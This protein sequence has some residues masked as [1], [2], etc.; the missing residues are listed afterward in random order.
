MAHSSI[1][2]LAR[3]VLFMLFFVV[4][5]HWAACLFIYLGKWQLANAAAGWV[6]AQ[7]GLFPWLVGTCLRFV[8][9]TRLYTSALYWTLTT[10]FTVGFGDIVPTSNI[11]RCYAITLQLVGGILQGIVFGNIGV[12][13]Y[14]FDHTNNKLRTALSD[15]AALQRCHHLPDALAKRMRSC[16]RYTWRQTQGLNTPYLLSDLGGA[17]KGDV[18]DAQKHAAAFSNSATFSDLPAGFVRALIG[19]L[20]MQAFLPDALIADAGE[21]GSELFFI[22]EGTVRVSEPA[23]DASGEEESPPSFDDSGPVLLKPGDMFGEAETILCEKRSFTYKAEGFVTCFAL[24]R[25]DLDIVLAN[26][27][28][29]VGALTAK[30]LARDLRSSSVRVKD[31]AEEEEAAKRLLHRVDTVRMHPHEH[32][33]AMSSGHHA[34]ALSAPVHFVPTP[35]PSS[36]LQDAAAMDA[37]SWDAFD[38]RLRAAMAAHAGLMQQCIAS[39]SRLEQGGHLDDN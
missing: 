4:I 19:R 9:T 14:G 1:G 38:T 3:V 15:V 17:L 12:A 6:N 11:E 20:R 30:V 16:T 39:I 22:A 5:S 8:D 36:S 29:L 23:N 2:N 26:Y 28:E 10:M 31:C 33:H 7:S 18:L 25:N 13:L 35:M 27:P 34:G 32:H 37:A 24:S 21:P